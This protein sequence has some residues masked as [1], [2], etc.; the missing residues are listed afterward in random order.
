LEGLS[1]SK[2]FNEIPQSVEL[3][4]HRLQQPPARFDSLYI[5]LCN[6]HLAN[7]EIWWDL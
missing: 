3:L 1:L 5:L 6:A 2:Q 7:T 4:T